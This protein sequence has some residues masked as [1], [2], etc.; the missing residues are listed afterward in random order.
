MGTDLWH[1]YKIP[2]VVLAGEVGSGKTMWGLT[3]DDDVF[4][5]NVDSPTVVWD[6]EGSSTPYENTLNFK[7]KDVSSMAG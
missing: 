4:N 2:V 7:R 3:V 6:V 5:P 1:P